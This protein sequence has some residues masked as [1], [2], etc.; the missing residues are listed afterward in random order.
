MA[1]VTDLIR[2]LSEIPD[3]DDT[4]VVLHED[5]VAEP[6]EFVSLADLLAEIER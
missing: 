3:P 4:V 5:D 6:G 2:A 1:T